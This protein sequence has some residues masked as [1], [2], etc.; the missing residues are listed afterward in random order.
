MLFSLLLIFDTAF[1]KVAA[2][3]NIYQ[4][5]PLVVYMEKELAYPGFGRREEWKSTVNF[6]NKE[7][8]NLQLV[9]IDNIYQLHYMPEH[10]KT[11]PNPEEAWAALWSIG[12]YAIDKNK[13]WIEISMA[14][15]AAPYIEFPKG[16]SSL[17]L[18]LFEK[19]ARSK[20]GKAAI[21]VDQDLVEI[22]NLAPYE[23]SK[24]YVDSKTQNK[25]VRLYP[26][27]IKATGEGYTFIDKETT[28]NEQTR[29]NYPGNIIVGIHKEYVSKIEFDN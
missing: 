4:G 19:F 10:Y 24:G 20:S 21:W 3:L 22:I 6:E 13:K 2:H 28:S 8:K 27:N 29:Y 7:T 17:K 5:S 15:S 14:G 25:Y 9:R 18:K 1:F 12:Y 16:F 11:Y 23:S 26:V